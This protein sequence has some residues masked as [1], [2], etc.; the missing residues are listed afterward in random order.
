MDAL[1]CWVSA[2]KI[3]VGFFS[4]L[5]N[6]GFTIRDKERERLARY[7]TIWN[8]TFWGPGVNSSASVPRV[9]VSHLPPEDLTTF[10]YTVPRYDN[11]NRQK[12]LNPR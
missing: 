7:M 4:R 6:L 11:I 10:S 8:G 1:L 3:G 12:G 9:W 5:Q 2:G